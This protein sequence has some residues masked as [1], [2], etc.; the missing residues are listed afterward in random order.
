MQVKKSNVH[1][2]IIGLF[3]YVLFL[4]VHVHLMNEPLLSFCLK[5]ISTSIRS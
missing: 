3:D 2:Q 1:L 4:R 5:W